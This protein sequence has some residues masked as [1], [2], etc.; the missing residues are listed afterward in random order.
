MAR[1]RL[2]IDATATE[3]PIGRGGFTAAERIIT[4]RGIIPIGDLNGETAEVLSD[5]GAWR[6][7]TIHARG[8][9]QLVKVTVRR[10]VTRTILTTPDQ[11]WVALDQ[12]AGRAHRASVDLTRGQRLVML[13]GKLPPNVRPSVVGAVHGAVNGAGAFPRRRPRSPGAVTLRGS[14]LALEPSFPEQAAKTRNADGS[15]EVTDLPRYWQAPP[16]LDEAYA[17][18]YGYLAGLFATK[19]SIRGGQIQITSSDRALIE[20]A[21]TIA[22]LCGI[23]VG[24]EVRVER[25]GSRRYHSLT[26]SA[27]TLVARADEFFLLPEHRAAFQARTSTR[28]TAHWKVDSVI[29]TGRR[30]AVFYAE[31]EGGQM[32]TLAGHLAAHTATTGS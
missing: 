10:Y 32:L 23:G 12:H 6:P 9:A 21:Q 24:P 28:G 27:A 16:P 29:E 17:T 20:A 26:L 3:Q 4:N 25:R 11:G 18:L 22:I 19:G 14:T 5:N 7:A 1:R 8:R 15:V 2:R 13:H 30:A 31:V